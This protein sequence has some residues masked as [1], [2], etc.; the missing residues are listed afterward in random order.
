MLLHEMRTSA[1]KIGTIAGILGFILYG[2]GVAAA[3][4]AP[5]APAVAAPLSSD[6]ATLT[7]LEALVTK[8]RAAPNGP[9]RHQ[10]MVES[11][12]LFDRLS[13]SAAGALGG[14]G[15]PAFL[16]EVAE[17]FVGYAETLPKSSQEQ[18]RALA[19]A[20]DV[21]PRVRD[22][23]KQAQLYIALARVELTSSDPSDGLATIRKAN[24]LVVG[25]P[26]GEGRDAARVGL[27]RLALPL[28]S[29]EL[30]MKLGWG[31]DIGAPQLAQRAMRAVAMAEIARHRA[32]KQLFALAAVKDTDTRAA[33]LADHGEELATKG[34]FRRA[35]VTALAIDDGHAA[36]RDRVLGNIADKQFQRAVRPE[37]I[38]APYAI[39]DGAARGAML[40]R[41]SDYAIDRGRLAIAREIVRHLDT[42]SA[43]Y[44]ALSGVATRLVR[45]QYL[46]DWAATWD[47]AAAAAEA[48]AD[49][50]QQRAAYAQLALEAADA[51]DVGRAERLRVKLD[52][53]QASELIGRHLVLAE[54]RAGDLDAAI[55]RLP[56]LTSVAGRSAAAA[57]V[58]DALLATG[59]PDRAAT[60]AAVISAPADRVTQLLAEARHLYGDPKQ[61]S[62]DPAAALTR[63]A[64]ARDQLSRI[65][66]PALR[67]ERIAAVAR[68]YA[69]RAD[70]AAVD[71]LFAL[72]SQDGRSLIAP[73]QVAATARASGRDA[74]LASLDRLPQDWRD[75]GLAEIADVVGDGGNAIAAFD[76]A[77]KIGDE[78]I[79]R[80]ALRHVA[81]QQARAQRQQAEDSAFVKSHGRLAGRRWRL[82][83]VRPVPAQSGDAERAEE[84]AR[85]LHRC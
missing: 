74:A 63:L 22:S 80:R 3:G 29:I 52:D 82:D 24:T 46:I 31:T 47:G 9:T 36:Q 59:Q 18:E 43:R 8:A 32:G 37:S 17:A 61:P 40:V 2:A 42:S 1:Y 84:H 70:V 19:D 76:V 4:D 72:A 44:R 48:I 83:L 5:T 28:P 57:A 49:G 77:R 68:L 81:E 75:R 62:Y 41:L 54:V 34:S 7:D 79:R 20:R 66:D 67:D 26:A 30:D 21:L 60:M 73:L 45:E 33:G 65:A 23:L 16:T 51:G 14:F 35:L 11:L 69:D 50:A 85:R 39:S 55:Q 27:I 6:K 53:A 38:I 56:G 64:A 78:H 25:L 12:L 58:Y 15:E 13:V 10:F 71:A